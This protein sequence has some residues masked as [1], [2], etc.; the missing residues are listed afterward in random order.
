MWARAQ[1]VDSFQR[2]SFAYVCGDFEQQIRSRNLSLLLMIIYYNYYI[3]YFDKNILEECDTEENTES[4]R[5]LTTPS[6]DSSN[7]YM[8]L[9]VKIIT[10]FIV[11]KNITDRQQNN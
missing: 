9:N 3:L 8:K 4:S 2:H 10:H 5:D 1:I 7:N 6:K 11:T